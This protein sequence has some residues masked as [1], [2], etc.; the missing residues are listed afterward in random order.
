MP[1]SL[2][3]GTTNR[4]NDLIGQDLIPEQQYNSGNMTFTQ[5]IGDR[6]TIFADGFYSK[7]TFVRLPASQ[8]ATLTVPQT[9][10]FFVRPPGFTGTSYTIAYNFINDLPI[11]RNPG[12]ATNWQVTP[13]VRLKLFG[14]FE[15]EGIFSYGKGNDQS[16]TYRGLTTANLNA[17]LAS[18]DPDA[19]LRSV[20]A[21][22][23]LRGNAGSG[24][25]TASSSP[26]R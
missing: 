14:D 19:R 7:R 16:N 20:R 15:A 10:A 2:V 23:H 26:P 17:A 5:E 25:A 18:S 22:P 6:V 24:S 21:W 4:C 11:N 13:G 3:A 9:N 8:S 1:A 12:S